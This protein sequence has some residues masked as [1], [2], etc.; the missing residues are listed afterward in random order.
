MA[1]RAGP[2][3]LIVQAENQSGVSAAN[4]RE[5]LL[6]Q[7]KAGDMSDR[8]ILAHVEGIVGAHE[9]PIGAED[10]DEVGELVFG[11]H[12]RVEID[13]PQICCRR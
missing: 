3:A 1:R 7:V 5:G 11:E 9:D 12:D 4:G 6:I 10:F 8:V 2:Q 13:L